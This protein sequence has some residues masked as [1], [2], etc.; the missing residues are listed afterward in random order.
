MRPGLNAISVSLTRQ[1]LNHRPS[2]PFGGSPTIKAAV[3]AVYMHA[4]VATH[5][6]YDQVSTQR[7]SWELDVTGYVPPHVKAC[8]AFCGILINISAKTVLNKPIFG[9]FSALRKLINDTIFDRYIFRLRHSFQIKLFSNVWTFGGA[10][11][12]R[13]RGGPPVRP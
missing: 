8:N 13:G 11:P 1:L 9:A 12:P 3:V 4:R 5:C 10:L 6:W 7:E 2:F